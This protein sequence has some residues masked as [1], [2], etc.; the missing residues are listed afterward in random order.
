L[1]QP[2]AEARFE[3]PVLDDELKVINFIGNFFENLGAFVKHGIIDREISCDLWARVVLTAWNSLLPVITIRRRALKSRALL[4]NFEYLAVL[5]E[6]Y[7]SRYPDGIYPRGMRRM[8]EA[9]EE[10]LPI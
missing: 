3:R 1:K 10:S 4:E 2:G 9:P 8:P 7:I 6:D 5:S